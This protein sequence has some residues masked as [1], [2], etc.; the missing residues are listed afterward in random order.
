LVFPTK[1]WAPLSE[2]KSK[3]DLTTPLYMFCSPR[4]PSVKLRR[5]NLRF[6]SRHR[7]GLPGIRG[8]PP[9]TPNEFQVGL[10]VLG[11]GSERGTCPLL[12]RGARPPRGSRSTPFFGRFGFFMLFTHW[13]TVFITRQPDSGWVHRPRRAPTLSTVSFFPLCSLF[14]DTTIRFGLAQKPPSSFPLLFHF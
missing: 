1:P 5:S 7:L 6:C 11:C 14:C 13:G 8:F 4:V 3:R 10:G 12:P 9:P 2:K